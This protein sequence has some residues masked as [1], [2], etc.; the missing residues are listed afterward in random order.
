MT[1]G[2][3]PAKRSR[4]NENENDTDERW[5]KR[6]RLVFRSMELLVGTLTPY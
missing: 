3:A 2:P 6:P 5:T 4:E 1:S